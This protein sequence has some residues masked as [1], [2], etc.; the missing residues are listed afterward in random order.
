MNDGEQ[1]SILKYRALAG[2]LRNAEVRH[3][4][5]RERLYRLLERDL[6]LPY[7]A[8]CVL[9]ELIDSGTLPRMEDEEQGESTDEWAQTHTAVVA[10]L[11]MGLAHLAQEGGE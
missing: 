4:A 7:L 9:E 8:T 2:R 6:D 5:E 11:K 1:V 3:A 10:A